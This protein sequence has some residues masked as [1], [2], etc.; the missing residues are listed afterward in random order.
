MSRATWV[1]ALLLLCAGCFLASPDALEWSAD[2]PGA[3]DD[4]TGSD[5]DDAVQDLDGDGHRPPD[6]CNDADATVYPG[7]PEIWDFQR[8]DCVGEPSATEVLSAAL[9]DGEGQ[10][11]GILHDGDWEVFGSSWSLG[12]LNGDGAED[13]C[14]RAWSE[15]NADIYVFLDIDSQLATGTLQTTGGA[16]VRVTP[17]HATPG[18][19][20]CSRDLHGDGYT[21]L[22]FSTVDVEG[23]TGAG[24]IYVY[25]G[26]ADF[27]DDPVL[28]Q[29]DAS[30]SDLDAASWTGRCW[31][32]GQLDD[33]P[34]LEIVYA[35]IAATAGGNY[36]QTLV[37]ATS[38]LV[39]EG[40]IPIYLLDANYPTCD[41]VDDLTGDG[42]SEVVIDD[43]QT[44]LVLGEDHDEDPAMPTWNYGFGWQGWWAA[45]AV[46]ADITGDGLREL[47]MGN[48]YWDEDEDD[49][50]EGAVVIYFGREGEALWQAAMEAS[51][52][53]APGRMVWIEGIGPSGGFGA[54]V[55][56]L[57][58]PSRDGFGDFAASSPTSQGALVPD[59]E[60]LVFTGRSEGDWEAL[61]DGQGRISPGKETSRFVGSEAGHVTDIGSSAGSCGYTWRSESEHTP[62]IW[63]RASGEEGR[64]VLLYW[65]NQRQ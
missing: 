60:A 65:V 12:D 51:D 58:D 38:N 4:D 28:D 23:G 3:D 41:V 52:L 44:R 20:D 42:T 10:P 56:P 61:A 11:G 47:I 33:D 49:N 8:N 36:E 34:E 57:G 1:L 6:D 21:D 46:S 2:E 31:G 18:E 9:P 43:G 54:R 45:S 64:G 22:V 25:D 29:F 7:A 32:I 14:A 30:I 63:W 48:P 24:G 62:R 37:V 5:D 35:T 27:G 16:D 19:L 55:C 26:G 17:A 40:F 53:P 50:A 59:G 13:L 15:D 39:P